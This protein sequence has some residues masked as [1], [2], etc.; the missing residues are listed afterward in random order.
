MKPLLVTL[1]LAAASALPAEAAGVWVE[2][3]RVRAKR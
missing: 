1:I 2:A 3:K